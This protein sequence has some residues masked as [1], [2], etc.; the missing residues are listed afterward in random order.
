MTLS[1]APSS[2]ICE[3]SPFCGRGLHVLSAIHYLVMIFGGLGR[4][5][6]AFSVGLEPA[7]EL[8]LV[9]QAGLEL[10]EICLPLPPECWVQRCVPPPPGSNDFFNHGK[11]LTKS[12]L[13]AKQA[14]CS[15]ATP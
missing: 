10:T 14:L 2:E 8:A 12:L 1:L 4:S 7:R 13:F 15:A 6:K 3:V 9:D 11:F 5:R